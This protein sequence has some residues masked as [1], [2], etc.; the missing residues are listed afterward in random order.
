MMASRVEHWCDACGKKT[1]A[2]T[3]CWFMTDAEH[4]STDHKSEAVDLCTPCLEKMRTHW[5]TQKKYNQEPAH[6]QHG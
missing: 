1:E 2:L 3:Y 6:E 5:Q 4:R